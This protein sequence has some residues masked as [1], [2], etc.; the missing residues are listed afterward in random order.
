MVLHNIIYQI[1]KVSTDGEVSDNL[2]FISHNSPFFNTY[3]KMFHNEDVLL[4]LLY[5]EAKYFSIDYEIYKVYK[6]NNDGEASDCIGYI[7]EDLEIF[8]DYLE[9]FGNGSILLV[10][11]VIDE[12]S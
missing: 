7:F 2:G 6:I 12:D 3:L 10:P 5:E 4:T 11:N 8:D 1:H 9:F